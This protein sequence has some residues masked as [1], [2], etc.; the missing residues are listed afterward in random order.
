MKI[1]IIEKPISY[2][3]GLELQLQS[4]EELASGKHYGE[5]FILQHDPPVI[6][7][8][9]NRGVKELKISETELLKRGYDYFQV[10]RGGSITVHEPGQIVIYIVAPV[11]SKNAG[12]FI[13]EFMKPAGLCLF[14]E[15]RQKVVYDEKRPG[16]WLNN[17]KVASVGLDLR[18]GIS[19]HGMAINVN[20]SLEGFQLVNPCGMESSIISSLKNET[21]I[22][23][24]LMEMKYKLEYYFTNHFECEDKIK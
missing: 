3:E 21:D 12:E 17:K 4:R 24:D 23:F 13:S 2:K 5:I 8:G 6:T 19:M 16:L 20:N 9:R 1:H 10:D 11:K 7:V 18:G 15:Y 14:D 22:S